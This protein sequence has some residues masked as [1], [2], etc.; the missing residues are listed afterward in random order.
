MVQFLNDPMCE[1]IVFYL[2]AASLLVPD[3]NMPAK[4]RSKIVY[5]VRKAVPLVL[6]Q[7]NM[8]ESLMM[9]DILPNVLE[10]LSV[11]CDDVMFPLL[12]NPVNQDGWTSVIVN[13]MKVESQDL[14]N[15]IAQMKGFAVNRTIL[16]LPISIN[17]IMEVA[18]FVARG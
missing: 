1:R 16:P 14:R 8:S 2:N 11:L 5:F 3:F 10:S 15:A 12:N 18:P 6:E 13:D 17:Q 7:G 4:T 9:G